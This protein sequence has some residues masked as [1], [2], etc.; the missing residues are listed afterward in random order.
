VQSRFSFHIAESV[1]DSAVVMLEF[2]GGALGVAESGIVNPD[3]FFSI[4]VHGTA[5]ILA[6][7]TL[8]KGKLLL[9]EGAHGDNGDWR[10]VELQPAGL[11]PL[12][13]WARAILHGREEDQAL[14]DENVAE[15]LTLS[16][17]V[18][19][20]YRSAA[21]GERVEVHAVQL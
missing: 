15:A 5:G 17:V 6:F 11:S 9:S 7:G 21:T 20:A 13:L 19:A 8:T 2:A 3:R 18:E 12:S 4:E 16:A 1:E 14:L 10:V